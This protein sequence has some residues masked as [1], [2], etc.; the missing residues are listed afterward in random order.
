VV[1]NDG[2]NPQNYANQI[3]ELLQVAMR[4]KRET[5]KRRMLTDLVEP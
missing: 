5:S 1:D 3:Y 2:N 4:E